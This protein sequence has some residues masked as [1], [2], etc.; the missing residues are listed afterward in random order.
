MGKTPPLL[1]QWT[2]FLALSARRYGMTVREM[3]RET[4]VTIRTVY[5]DLQTLQQAGFPLEESVS[6]HGRKHWR[7]ARHGQGLPMTFNWEEAISLY[8]GRRFLEP[9]AGTMF[10]QG[11]QSAF[12]KIRAVLGEPALRY[13]EKMGAAVHHTVIGA[14]DYAKKTQIID[15]LMVGIE[16]RKFTTLT[17]QSLQA[18]E[19]VTYDVYPYGV[20]Y[21]EGSLYLVAFAPDHGKVRHYK[22]DRIEDAEVQELRF[23]R[24]D[25]FDLQE[26]LAHSFGIFLTS[27]DDVEIK[28]KFSPKVARYV[29]ESRWHASQQLA[30]QPDGSLIAQFRLADTDE[31]KRWILS[32]GS[33]AVVLEP[34]GLRSEI[35]ADITQLR[36][37]YESDKPSTTQVRR[38]R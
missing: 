12:S 19:P 38:P 11:A 4:D 36:R 27:G 37:Q 15:S 2:L 9:L 35:L 32:F 3:A 14:S 18:T 5:R 13:I 23:V 24:P 25:S 16:D 6:D 10:W 7:I 31:I 28:V 1:R 17:Y 26:H 33:D 30:T 29:R 20:V 8:W 22:V 34:D 21:H